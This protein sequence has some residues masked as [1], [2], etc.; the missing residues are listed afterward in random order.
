MKRNCIC[1][2]S[3]VVA[4]GL[5]LVAPR[6]PRA[7][8]LFITEFMAVNSFGLQDEDGN[9]SDWVEV[10]NASSTNIDLGGWFLTDD[11]GDL[12]RWAFPSTHVPPGGFVVVFASDKD[13]A[14][15]GQE[16]H[17][18]FRLSSSG[19]Y[20]ALVQPDGLTP[21]HAFSPSYPRQYA[22]LAYGLAWH[23]EGVLLLE[24]NAPC[25][26]LV[27]S[28]GSLGTN[29]IAAAGF[30][31]SAW[32]GGQTG[33]GY[34]VDASPQYGDDVIG[35]D[36]EDVM[37]DT[38]PT[39]Y[40]RIPFG[41]APINAVDGLTLRMK[42]DDG[43]VAYINGVAVASTNAPASPQWNS[44]AT[45][46]HPDAEA[47]Q[48]VDFEYLPPAGFLVTGT[49]MLAIQGLNSG[50]G[51]SD[52]LILP[53]LIASELTV[54]AETER[55]FATP[56]PGGANADDYL[57][58]VADT[59]FSNDRGFYTSAFTV[60]ITTVTDG[61]T[62]RYTLDG[63]EPTLS[64]GTNYTTAITVADT[65]ILRAAAFKSGYRPTNVDT[66]TYIFPVEVIRQPAVP[67]GFP[68]EWLTSGGAR[69]YADYEMDPEI[70]G[71]PLY[72]NRIEKGLLS[73]PTLSLVTDVNHLFDQQTGFY[74][75][76]LDD[77]VAWERPVSMELIYPSARRD[78]QLDC[79]VRVYGGSSRNT[80]FP[81][82][83][84]RLLFKG[85]YGASR[86]EYPL[87]EGDPFC[88]RAVDTFDTVILRGG[89]NNTWI[90]RH[91]FQAFRSQYIRDQWVRDAQLDM[92]SPSCHGTYF[93]LY[94][95]GLY[96][97]V[98]NV[99]ERPSA[100]F[101]ASYFG[102]EKE[103]YDAQNVNQ[104]ID[105]D[106]VAWNTMM[107]MANAGL[108]SNA[109]YEAIQEY[110]DVPQLADYMLLNFYVGNDDWDGHNWYA[111]RRRE[112]GAGYRFFSWDA[113]LSI[114]RHV[115]SSPP[116]QPEYDTILGVNK[117]GPNRSNKPSRLFTKLRGNAEFRLLCADRIHRH[118]FNDGILTPSNTVS[119]WRQRHEQ[120]FDA[121]VAESARWGD[122]KRDINPGKYT[123][124]DYDLFHTDEH[125]LAHQEWLLNGYFPRRH[126]IVLDQL[127]AV[128]CYPDTAAPV[129]SRF[130]G[131]ITNGFR[132][133]ITAAN[134]VFYTLDGSDPRE[135]GT[136][137]AVGAAYGG[138]VAL[139]RTTHVKARANNGGDWSALVEAVFVLDEP[140]PLRISEIMYNPRRASG[141]GTNGAPLRM[142]FEFLELQ[143][144][145]ATEIGLAGVELIDGVSF[146]FK[147][148]AV[149]TLSP[150]AHVLVVRDLAAFKSRY[151][152]WAG[153]RIAGE[154]VF[155]ADALGDDGEEIELVD[156]LGRMIERFDYADDWYPNT[157][158][159]GF[160]LEAVDPG[161]TVDKGAASAWRASSFV[162]GSPGFEDSAAYP[163]G[164]RIVISEVLAHQDHPGGD[165][166]DWIELHNEGG[167]A[168]D[169]GGW[170]LSDSPNRPAKYR[171]PGGTGLP[172]NGYVVFT[173]HDHFGT[174]AP[175]AG[176]NGF[177]LSELGDRVVLS[178]G[179]NGVLTGYYAAEEFGASG[180]DDTFGRYIK[181]DGDVDFPI[182]GSA[183]FG[184]SNAYPRVGPVVI[185]EI[186]YNLPGDD[187]LEFIELYNSAATRVP[188][189]DAARPGNTWTLRGGV[190]FAFPAGTF[191][192]ATNFV[193]LIRTDTN[194]FRSAYPDCPAGV[195]LLGPYDGQ[196]D[197]AGESLRLYRPGAPEP[198]T[199]EVPEIL[200]DRV[201]YDD[202]EPWPRDADGAGA[203]LV[204]RGLSGYG[205]DSGNWVAA[206]GRGT[207]GTHRP[208]AALVS[209][210][211]GSVF[212][213]PCS[214]QLS[215]AIDAGRIPSVSFVEFLRD[216]EA[217]AS[218][219]SA[220]YKAAIDLTEPGSVEMAARVVYGGG[221]VTSEVV[222]VHGLAIETRPAT[223]VTDSSATLN[224]RIIGPC[225]VDAEF[226]WGPVD[227]GTNADAW[228]SGVSLSSVSN[229]AVALPLTGLVQGQ[230]YVC[231]LR[232]KAGGRTGW[233]AGTTVFTPHAFAA[234][235]RTMDIRLHGYGRVTTLTNFPALVRLGPHI[236]GFD[237]GHFAE[238]GGDLRFADGSGTALNYEIDE[239]NPAGV[240]GLWV[241]VPEVQGTGSVIHAYWGHPSAEAPPCLTNGSP[242]S[243]G[244]K[245]VWHFGGDPGD[246]VT[247]VRFA[248]DH[249]S[250]EAAGVAGSG[251][252][253]GGSA[254][255]DPVFVS[256]EWYWLHMVD[257]LTVSLWAR[258]SPYQEGQVFGT[259]STERNLFVGLVGDRFPNWRFA[260][261]NAES[262]ALTARPGQWQM[263]GLVLAAG[264]AVAYCDSVS[265][266]VGGFTEFV[267]DTR[268][269]L[270][271]VNASGA[272]TNFYSGELDEV[273]LSAV[274]RSADWLWAEFATVE[275][276]DTF[277]AYGAVVPTTADH[278]G[279]SMPDAWETDH[280]EGTNAAAGA[281]P[282][283]DGLSNAGEYV[284]GT[285]PTN[286]TSRFALSFVLSNGLTVVTIPTVD[287]SAGPSGVQRYYSLERSTNAVLLR[288]QGVAGRTN[289]LGQGQFIRHTG[290]GS[291]PHS[292][293]RG[294]VRLEE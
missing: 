121:L 76:P 266:A 29:W 111:G 28:D 284:A 161:G 254:Y 45:D 206:H 54:D 224:G 274:A 186:M 81:K 267:P 170:Y 82:K 86:L 185:S 50:S 56:T 53:E 24:T 68:A 39:A 100:S 244:Y 180:R 243:E 238:T 4:A 181:S 10:H 107:A 97:G 229:A 70:T 48:F 162:D 228:A 232:A 67:A 125:Y 115:T 207:P 176:T 113:E 138:S 166:G 189:H 215:A 131:E 259:Q 264:Q 270:G 148:G 21:V 42:Y 246:S 112:A 177:A 269:L 63:S 153:M 47:L 49:N 152:G 132:L 217:V 220:P 172:A 191:M 163:S 126:N 245:A 93:H 279:D 120:I 17:A 146:D 171:I 41:Y 212:F 130:G 209:P 202:K 90:H 188:L 151:P 139:A 292:L 252:L 60:A 216:G 287:A 84:L 22:D 291:R 179:T 20:L 77:G 249:G 143:N 114:S 87:F 204:R 137:N 35:L 8:S 205:N 260:V 99:T 141:G 12:Q 38:H 142:D 40:I 13:R 94:I 184:S 272:A 218:D 283:G 150:G 235:T 43:F 71:H 253:L 173:E 280:L 123:A 73:L 239:W 195:T 96:W 51:S 101:L 197:N 250:T 69:A 108:A 289:V 88:S 261:Q 92:G 3:V 149:A 241:Q 201:K 278:D 265:A 288:W 85:E 155:P 290:P 178:S 168:V 231:R 135:Y 258:P 118:M 276:H 286:A 72:S 167:G 225:E 52:F 145:S 83:T 98:Y 199:G 262:T 89:H 61:A 190:Q 236:D 285:D 175:G 208:A 277:T 116:P 26:A 230:G 136:G 294:Q 257:G 133:A 103:D 193:L 7:E 65:T 219:A 23:R 58:V 66:H 160:S 196:L 78:F 134:P 275:A 271:G 240:S 27:P 30:D 164:G 242:W 234:W 157:D 222:L 11:V 1:S 293:Y 187:G 169:I 44:A 159:R 248:L 2:L 9:Y 263:V 129:F 282:D 31:D 5:A 37:H 6:A 183:T 140:S 154:F 104:A 34:D 74:A 214:V 106:L 18:N 192:P 64:H 182:L 237:Y 79:G 124:D 128:N 221:V 255:L 105:G 46:T 247:G 19:E 194:T 251:R 119:R 200:V 59:Q 273:R 210:A 281:D 147:R 75:N 233:S 226:F 203:S 211:N 174:N 165:P 117:V 95:N 256:R 25:R 33:V 55:Y 213:A 198:L 57:G 127:R 158:G 16:L 227:G 91:W 122:H 110:L 156:G 102:G 62:I 32:R 144:T 15:S 36:V 223:A 80:D 109:D 268:S 14:V